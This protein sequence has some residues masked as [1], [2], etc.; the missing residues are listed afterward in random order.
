MAQLLSVK[1]Q[2]GRVGNAVIAPPEQ[3]TG[4]RPAPPPQTSAIIWGGAISAVPK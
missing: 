4:C 3:A 1:G 2:R